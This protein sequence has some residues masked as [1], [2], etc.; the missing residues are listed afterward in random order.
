M[1]PLH[2]SSGTDTCV[3]SVH[4]NCIAAGASY[5]ATRSS[6][7]MKRLP[8][9]TISVVGAT[10][11]ESV[12]LTRRHAVVLASCRLLQRVLANALVSHPPSGSPGP[13]GR[14]VPGSEALWAA[15]LPWM[16]SVPNL[17]WTFREIAVMTS[18]AAS[19][20][21]LWGAWGPLPLCI[22]YRPHSSQDSGT[23]IASFQTPYVSRISRKLSPNWSVRSAGTSGRIPL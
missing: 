1:V 23:I 18:C 16:S 3:P 12:S 15:C 2:L 20:S 21:A 13:G 4:V 8:M 10:R 9:P 17:S 14:A 5:A 7:S 6:I 22:Y 19:M 11:S